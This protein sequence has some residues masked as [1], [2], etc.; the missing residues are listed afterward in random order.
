M[1]DVETLKAIFPSW[2]ED[3]LALVLAESK[4]SI[5]EAA[6]KISEG[7]SASSISRVRV[8]LCVLVSSSDQGRTFFRSRSSDPSSASLAIDKGVH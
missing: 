7:K 2:Q 8:W 5:D 3:D 1:S 4:G 6:T